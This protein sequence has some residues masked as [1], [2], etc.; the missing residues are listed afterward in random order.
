MDRGQD[1]M[2]VTRFFSCM[3]HVDLKPIDWTILL[4]QSIRYIIY[5]QYYYYGVLLVVILLGRCS[6][7]KCA[8]V[9]FFFL[10]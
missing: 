5:L 3:L 7:G 6:R 9:S 1:W 8:F 4:Q 10:S 2:P